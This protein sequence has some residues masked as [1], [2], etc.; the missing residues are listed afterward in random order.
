MPKRTASTHTNLQIA[1]MLN[2][3]ADML[4]LKEEN[5]FKIAAHRRA[6]DSITHLNQD[7]R[8]IWKNDAA[9]L[10]AINGVGEG[11][12]QKIDELL[13]TGDMKYYRELAATIPEGVLEFLRIPDVGPKTAMRLWKDLGVTDIEGLRAALTA[14][15]VRTIAGMSEKSEANLLAGLDSLSRKTNRRRISEADAFATDMLNALRAECG[16]LIGQAEFAGSLRRRRATIGDLDLLASADKRH[17]PRL[18]EAFTELPHVES[19]AEHG[20]TKAVIVARNGMQVDLRVLE[21]KHWGC[22]MIYFTGSKEHNITIRGM[23]QDLGMSLNEY[24]FAKGKKQ[25]FCETEEEVYKQVG[26]SWIPPELRENAGEIEAAREGKLPTLI[27]LEDLKGDLQ[28]HSTW[29][30]G[31]VSIEEMA[32][33]AMARGL[34]YLAVTDHSSG[35]G[36][37]QGVNATSIKRQWKEIDAVNKKLR[38]FTVLKGLE[39]E[40]RADGSLDMPDEI[41][42]QL[43]ICLAS[44]H[45]AQKQSAERI[46]ARVTKAMRHPYVDAIAHPTGRL[47][48]ERESSALDV[49]EAMRVAQETGTILEVDGAP[50][51]LDLDEVHVRRL[52]ELGLKTMIDSDAH[53]PDAF[54]GLQYGIGNARRGWAEARDVI[55]TLPWDRAKKDLKR[56][57]R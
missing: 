49:A 55:N 45:T 10:R 21:P 40:I 43:D 31:A 44:T 54:A 39:L 57:R 9:N 41:L 52:K 46:T 19:V 28:T 24:R 33:A 18:L 7:I 56:N 35:L 51:R 47:I 13:R 20:D 38:G 3:I 42:A 36:V 27:T 26:L 11:I 16:R 53:H 4:A 22:A 2:R 48:E 34:T 30:D 14:G 17:H 8:D 32:R 25:I 50:E 15:K 29:S 6:A 12:G 37:T 23:A 1:E 5:T